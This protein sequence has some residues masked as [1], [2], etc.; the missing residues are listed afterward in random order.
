MSNTEQTE[1]VVT[2][3]EG[4]QGQ[5]KPGFEALV[6]LQ[7]LKQLLFVVTP[8]AVQRCE[9]TGAGEG[10]QPCLPVINL[11]KQQEVK[12]IMFTAC[13][14]KQRLLGPSIQFRFI[15]I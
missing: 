1:F 5:L 10:F 12:H 8:E 6:F 3:D 14:T 13:E 9:S 2:E 15:T 7:L 11:G 4:E